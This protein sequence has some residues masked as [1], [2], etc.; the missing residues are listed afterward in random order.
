MAEIE[1]L[2]NIPDISFID[3]KTLDDVKAA[4]VTDYT[5]AFEADTGKSIALAPAAPMRLALEAAATQ[6]YQAMQY[7]DRAGKQSTIK[8]SYGSYLDNLAA[9]KGLTRSEATAATTTLRFTLSAVQSSAVGIPAGTRATPGTDGGVYFATA[10]YAEVPAGSLSVDVAAKCTTSGSSGNGYAAG[11]IATIVDPV[12]YVASVVNT[13]ASAGGSNE[14]S[15]AD[16]SERIFL[17]PSSYSTAG[18]ADA[19]KYWVE[20]YNSAIGDVLVQRG[21]IDGTVIITMLMDDGSLPG[22]EVVS[23]VQSFLDAGNVRPLTDKVTVQAPAEVAYN[24]ALT[25]YIAKSDSAQAVTIQAAVT[26]AGAAYT[27]WQR[28]LGRDVNPSKLTAL[29]VAAGAKRVEITAPT[30]TTISAVQVAK[31]G[32]SSVTYGGLE[33]D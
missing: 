21:D 32:T 13:T 26:A 15:D 9:L 7:I 28:K 8:Y 33:D 5:A 25:Y 22:T 6:I 4:M 12:S 27:K 19:Y 1:A 2:K 30:H 17:A 31:L 11:T 24:I 14:E 3:S 23:G 10:V 29:V 16:L 18:P 20:A